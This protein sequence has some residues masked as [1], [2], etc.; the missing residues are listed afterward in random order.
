M[1]AF[2]RK[3]PMTR[4]LTPAIHPQLL[5]YLPAIT[6]P[7]LASLCLATA[8][9]GLVAT[10]ASVPAA[11]HL[12]GFGLLGVAA[13]GFVVAIARRVRTRAR[14]VRATHLLKTGNPLTMRLV[15]TR[16]G[17]GK[18]Y[19]DLAPV[20]KGAVQLLAKWPLTPV[21]AVS[22][23]RTDKPGH[24]IPVLVPQ[25]GVGTGQGT[26]LQAEVL[27]DPTDDSLVIIST[28]QGCLL[29]RGN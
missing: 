2:A 3:S 13:I 16:V 15:L 20:K 17:R 14:L 23:A 12:T 25:A 9:L 6:G 11:W 1:M 7:L 5:A 4:R 22:N 26:S 8:G 28:R 27:V 19:A 24:R 10:P 21:G 29:S 18:A